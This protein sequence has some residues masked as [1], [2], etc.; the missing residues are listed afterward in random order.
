MKTISICLFVLFFFTTSV[1]GQKE[2]K[3]DY[4]KAYSSALKE[5]TSFEKEHGHNFQT[6]NVNMHYYLWGNK[7]G[8]PFI[9][10]HGTFSNGTE[11]LDFVDTLVNQNYFVVAID[12]Y[13]HGLTSKPNKEVSI[14]DVAD[15][16]NALLEHLNIK[17]TIVG[18][19]SR[20][21]IIAAAF[22]QTYPAKVKGLIL[23]DG[24]GASFLKPRQL[25][26]EEVLKERYEKMYASSNDTLFNSQFEAFK[27]YYSPDLNDSQYWWFYLLKQSKNGQWG[28]NIGLKEW[29]GQTNAQ[30]GLR[31]IYK[32][33]T[34]PLFE[35]SGL[36]FNP[37]I[38]FRNLNIPI[39]IFDPQ[40]D[41]TDGF[42]NLSNQ[43]EELKNLH[44]NQIKLLHFSECGHA[45]HYEQLEQFKVE[46]ISFLNNI[47]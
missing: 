36:L 18:G 8:K 37:K 46:I 20:G 26:D 31:N 42:F 7:T 11:I 28:L 23:E 13:G 6:K 39:L 16:M 10:V 15:D 25:L 45:V 47:K 43:Y 38:A 24:G 34:A 44:P 3:I 30:D 32:T 1:N 17:Q 35:A 27:F 19:W 29:L 41:D 14:Y 40:G 21:G 5:Y 4:E 2:P 12:Y 9:W 22:Y 33:T